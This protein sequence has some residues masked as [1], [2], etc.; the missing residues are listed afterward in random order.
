M[1]RLADANYVV[2]DDGNVHRRDRPDVIVSLQ[3][4]SSLE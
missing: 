4:H 1:H 3:A 2:I